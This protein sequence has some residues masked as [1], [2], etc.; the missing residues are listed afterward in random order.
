MSR[1]KM[2][3]LESMHVYVVDDMTKYHIMILKDVYTTYEVHHDIEL[4]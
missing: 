4:L 3:R 2:C 1:R